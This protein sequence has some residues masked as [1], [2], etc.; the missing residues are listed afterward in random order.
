MNDLNMANNGRTCSK[1]Y[2]IL[3]HRYLHLT[4]QHLLMAYVGHLWLQT[5]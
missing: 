5:Y 1:G 3:S 4:Q 2:L